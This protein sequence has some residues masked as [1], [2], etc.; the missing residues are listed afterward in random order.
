M[1]VKNNISASE[2]DII[3]NHMYSHT[4]NNINI[5]KVPFIFR[6]IKRR[7]DKT[8]VDT[9]NQYI[10]LLK[11]SIDETFNLHKSFMIEFTMFFRDEQ[12]FDLLLKHIIPNFIENNTNKKCLRIWIPGC[13]TGEEAYSFAIIVY[14]CLQ[15]MK[16]SLNVKIFATDIDLQA[17]KKANSG[18]YEMDIESS[19]VDEMLKKYFYKVNNTYKVVNE[20]RNMLVFGFHD[21]IISPPFT[22][23]D[24]ISCRNVLIYLEE[25]VQKN[26]LSI[27]HYS[28]S[29]N[30]ILVLGTSEYIQCLDKYFD[31][32]SLKLKIFSK[33][34]QE[35]D[36]RTL[37][38]FPTR[39]SSKK[40]FS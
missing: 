11:S 17:L 39:S 7:I 3:A 25:N 26:L 16:I 31:P 28:L 27:F 30:G 20:I 8:S 18:I 14:E 6:C 33:K 5:Y 13:S 22:Q 21:I 15:K 29:K 34:N 32:I 38:N 35:L 12:V 36:I 19:I 40:N 4:G 24:F 23:M 9:V 37:L 2:L 1:I 10:D